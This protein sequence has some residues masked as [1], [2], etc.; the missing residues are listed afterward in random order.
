NNAGSIQTE[1]NRKLCRVQPMSLQLSA[2]I[3]VDGG[4]KVDGRKGV[5]EDLKPRRV[6]TQ[7]QQWMHRRCQLGKGHILTL[8]RVFTEFAHQ[9]RGR[10]CGSACRHC[11]YGQTNVE[12]SSKKKTF[13]SFFY[14]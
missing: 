8:Y 11:P 7:K 6:R 3:H 13:N 9:Q 4:L 2:A 1:A 12:D 14:V 5:P 10:C